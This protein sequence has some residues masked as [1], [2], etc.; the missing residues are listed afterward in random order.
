M[1][2]RPLVPRQHAL[3]EIDPRILTPKPHQPFRIL[4]QRLALND[5][6]YLPTHFLPLGP[7]E[8]EQQSQFPI[9]RF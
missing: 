9:P 5:Q 8:I 2:P 1:F 4:Q 6:R 3:I 7:D